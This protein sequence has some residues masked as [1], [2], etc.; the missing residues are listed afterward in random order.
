MKASAFSP[1]TALRVCMVLVMVLG[2]A[3]MGDFEIEEDL[4]N[5]AND[6]AVGS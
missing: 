4:R 6:F 5:D 2:N 1:I 3:M